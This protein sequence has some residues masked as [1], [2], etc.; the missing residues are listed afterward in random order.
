MENNSEVKNGPVVLTVQAKVAAPIEKVWKYWNEPKHIMQWAFASDEWHAPAATN[1][2]SVG[3][4]LSTTMAAKDGSM[5]FE[6]WGIYSNIV[7]NEVIEYELGD[8]RKVKVVFEDLGSEVLVT[9]D[10]DAE[11]S[12]PL[13]MQQAGW[14]A[15]IDNFKKYVE[16]EEK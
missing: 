14:Q 3:G 12:H 7:P 6:F 8:G 15:I 1:D 10:F 9:E 13:E 5:S 2:L 4:K 11:G 16:N